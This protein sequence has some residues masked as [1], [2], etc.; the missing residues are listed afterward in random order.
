MT[1]NITRREVVQTG[2][3]AAILAAAGLSPANAGLSEV[4]A[5]PFNSGS[6]AEDVTAGLDLSGKTVL[7]TGVNSGMG[8]E[9][10]RVLAMR[11]AHVLGTARTK[12]KAETACKSVEGKT[13]PLVCELTDFASVAACANAAKAVG[14][15]IDV[16]ICNAGVMALQELQQVNGIEKHFVVN[17]LGHFVLVNHLL[18]TVRA[19]KQGRIVMISSF[20]YEKAHEDGIEFDNLSG[21]R[22]YDHRRAYAQS[23]LAN[24]LFTRSLSK[25]LSG[26][27]ATANAVDPGIVDTN[28]KRHFG[29]F[30]SIASF[31]FGSFIAKTTAEGASTAC[32]LATNPNLAEVSGQYFTDCQVT[33][34]N[35]NAR[36]DELATKLWDVSVELTKP[37][38][39]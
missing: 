26:S 16:L 38:L 15:P 10:M 17:H 22:D 39:A 3:V 6:T 33:E 19:S 35:D 13:T 1:F 21:E 2:S 23:K 12:E 34:T 37:Y 11:G 25:M 27:N 7:I 4:P 20:G 18:D 31:V 14:K 32:Y 9:T 36:D 28:L 24:L 30:M 5:S 8:L 29:W